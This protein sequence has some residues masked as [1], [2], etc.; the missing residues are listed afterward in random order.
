[1]SG[2]RPRQT[3]TPLDPRP[4]QPQ[5]LTP[6]ESLL[7]KSIPAISFRMNTYEKDRVGV[8][9]LPPPRSCLALFTFWGVKS[10][11]CHSYENTG[12]Y[13]PS[14]FPE[15]QRW[16]LT[17][18][19]IPLERGPGAGLRALLDG[20]AE[21]ELV[22]AS[23]EGWEFA[24]GA[25]VAGGDVVVEVVE[26]LD[27]GVG[28]AFGVSA[29]IRGVGASRGCQQRR[30]LNK[31]TVGF[32]AAADPQRV[33][34]LGVPGERAFAAV[35]FKMERALA[36]GADLGNGENAVNAMFQ[37]DQDR[38]VIVGLDGDFVGGDILGGGERFHVATRL[39][40]DRN[41]GG[42]IGAEFRDFFPGDPLNQIQPVRAN[43]GDGAQLPAQLGLQTPVPVGG[44]REPV[45]QEAAM[46]EA[47]FANGAGS[48]QRFGLNAQ[49]IV[50]EIV[51]HA[52]DAVG[53]LG[54]RDELRGF[55]RVH[56][57]RLFAQDVLAGAEEFGGLFKVDVV[58]RA[59][60]H[61]GDF[62]I[63]GNFFDAGVGAFKAEGFGGG[64]TAI[65]GADLC[66][67]DAD[68]NATER[69]DV[70]FAD[71]SGSDNGGYVVHVRELLS[72]AQAILPVP[73]L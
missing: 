23:G 61:G 36:P 70:G 32:I 73:Q 53:F 6:L 37:M 48:D 46:D 66:A 18:K 5:S 41:H 54:Q 50:T 62:G 58:G 59:D 43:V 68:G 69:F 47:D 52:A 7:T 12:G 13:T 4:N 3:P 22:V 35:D 17:V 34:I 40:A 10:C 16:I 2:A 57:Q 42:E 72:V 65:A 38:G 33:G 67:F 28:I 30:I 26:E 11:I 71:E 44:I 51:G 31:D 55:A 27:E 24:R 21:D 49:R 15:R 14:L 8:P 56:G 60:M 19:L 1:M 9:S 64:G 20:F 29:G 25:E 39:V 45:L 63:G